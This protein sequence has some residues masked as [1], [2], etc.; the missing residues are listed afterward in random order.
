M[1]HGAF[2]LL[3]A[4]HTVHG[5]GQVH[6]HTVAE[7]AN[8]QEAGHLCQ[9]GER[10]RID[11]AGVIC[12]KQVTGGVIVAQTEGLRF[13]LPPPFPLHLQ[14]HGFSMPGVQTRHKNIDIIVIR[15]GPLPNAG[16]L[17]TCGWLRAQP[18]PPST[19]PMR[20]AHLRCDASKRSPVAL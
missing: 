19:A 8:A 17:D 9:S 18:N 14:V 15:C 2:P 7:R 5:A 3:R 11:G 4:G 13:T 1:V 20:D 6:Q 16:P 12:L 10:Q